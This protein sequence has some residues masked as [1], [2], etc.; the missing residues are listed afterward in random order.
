[1]YFRLLHDEASGATGYLLADLGA[2]EA[3]LIDAGPEDAAV[4]AA[5]LDEH[6]LRLRWHLATHAHGESAA[7]G[8]GTLGALRLDMAAAQALPA[9][10][11]SGWLRFG[12][13]LLQVL[14]TPGHTP[15]CRSFLWRD[16]LFCG[17]ALAGPACPD[18]PWPAQPE[19]LWDSATS[20][21]LSLP[22]ETLVFSHH[23][24][25][26]SPVSTVLAQRCWHP[27]FGRRSRDDFLA[28]CA[29]HQPRAQAGRRPQ[30]HPQHPQ[31]P[32]LDRQVQKSA[33]VATP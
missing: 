14:P 13:E 17:D 4:W 6:R 5:M 29:T 3:V 32:P 18:Q 15:Q 26:A 16:R 33:N 27:W 11:H 12:N 24:P 20:R 8:P 10:T 22:A 23:S 19:Q 21:L 31:H 2:G 25:Q 7:Q 9:D 30:Q 28:L 1:M